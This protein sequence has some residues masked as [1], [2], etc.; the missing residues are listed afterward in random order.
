[1]TTAIVFLVLG[2]ILLVF[3]ADY[4]VKGASAIAA[5]LGIS[6]LVVGLTVVSFGTSAPELAVSI[7]SAFKGQAD[8]ALGNAV[9][10]N[11]CN[12]LLILGISSLIIPLIVNSQLVRLDVPV[13]IGTSLLL[14]ALAYDGSISRFDGILLFSIAVAYT[15]FLTYKSRKEQ[16]PAV[17][18][19]YEKEFGKT[20]E[21]PKWLRNIC[22]IVFG[23][24]GLVL[25]S[26]WLVDGAVLIARH[27]GV[28]ELII[29]LT[30]VSLGTSLPEVATSITAAIKGERDIAVGNVVGSNIFNIVVVLGLASI[31][32][33]SGIAVSPAALAFDIPFMIAISI[34]CFPVF[35]HGYTIGRLSGFIFLSFYLAYL[36]Y[37]VLQSIGSPAFPLFR[38]IT[39]FYASPL[40]ALALLILLIKAMRQG[41][42]ASGETSN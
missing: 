24:G 39:V 16:N 33:P 30:I 1:M 10:S 4:L 12:V 14:V 7:M 27:F 42:Q 41:P 6:P 11:I 20:G 25:G 9:G 34:A 17:L 19:E 18:S 5:D 3:A 29:G 40:A 21:K 38:Q 8:L 2:L 36:A 26:Q 37:L 28:S 32:A 15:V 22:F 23:I 35:F 31:V 13:M